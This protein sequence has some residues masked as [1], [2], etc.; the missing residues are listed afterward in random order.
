MSIDTVEEEQ[1][2]NG[3]NTRSVAAMLVDETVPPRNLKQ[4]WL[5]MRGRSVR[6]RKELTPLH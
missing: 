3:T 5:I 1:E 6:R 2:K 4:V